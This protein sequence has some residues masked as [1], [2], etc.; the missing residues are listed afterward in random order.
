[1]IKIK[2]MLNISKFQT[3]NIVS[4][5]LLKISV[6]LHHILAIHYTLNNL[7]INVQI[8]LRGAL[9]CDITQKNQDNTKLLV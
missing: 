5:T 1:M 3:Y 2:K 8:H 6:Y 7:S 9:L 4:Q